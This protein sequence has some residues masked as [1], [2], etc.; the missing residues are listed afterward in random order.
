LSSNDLAEAF[1]KW[2]L[3]IS[4]AKTNFHITVWQRVAAENHGVC[5][6]DNFIIEI[7]LPPLYDFSEAY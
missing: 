1:T 5:S 2:Q 3:R 4:P 7:T 6:S